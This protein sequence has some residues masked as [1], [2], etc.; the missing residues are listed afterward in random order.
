MSRLRTGA[1]AI[2]VGAATA[3]VLSLAGAKT[4]VVIGSVVVIVVAW[5]SSSMRKNNKQTLSRDVNSE[6]DKSMELSEVDKS[7]IKKGLKEVPLVGDEL[8]A[9]V[10]DLSD[11][12]KSDL[13]HECGYFTYKEKG[14]IRL[15]YTAFF[16]AFLQARGVYIDEDSNDKVCA[17]D[18]SMVFTTGDSVYEHIIG[19]NNVLLEFWELTSFSATY[20][21]PTLIASE[22]EDGTMNFSV[23]KGTSESP[24]RSRESYFYTIHHDGKVIAEESNE[25]LNMNNSQHVIAIILTVIRDVY[26]EYDFME[27]MKKFFDKFAGKDVSEKSEERKTNFQGDISSDFL[28]EQSQEKYAQGDIEGAIQFCNQALACDSKHLLSL[29]GRAFLKMLKGDCQG[30]IE[31]YKKRIEIEPGKYEGYFDLGLTLSKQGNSQEEAIQNFDRVIA[32]NPVYKQAYN[33]RAQEKRELGQLT[34]ALEDHNKAIELDSSYSI[35]Y[36]SRGATKYNLKDYE[37]AILD[38]TKAIVIDPENQDFYFNRANAKKQLGDLKGA[39]EDFKKAA[40]LGDE[41]AALLVEDYCQ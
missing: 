29:K 36:S 27:V 26:G 16:E 11:I 40:E 41:D 12:S 30:A 8:L 23:C 17:T 37:G 9:K 2:G 15:N 18:E 32:I 33:M 28:F 31:D 39:C 25:V 20:N 6:K 22:N 34:S 13:V 19:F 4:P 1:I 24:D 10:E 7:I 35:A 5:L 21:I 3:L 38:H 14:G